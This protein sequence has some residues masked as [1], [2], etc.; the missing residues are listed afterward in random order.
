[1]LLHLDTAEALLQ[2]YIETSAQ[3]Q[4]AAMRRLYRQRASGSAIGCS[5]DED[6]ALPQQN[7]SLLQAVR[8]VYTGVGVQLKV[9]AV[10]QGHL[11]LLSGAGGEIRA[12]GGGA[13][14][15]K[16]RGTGGQHHQH[17]Q[18]LAPLH[19]HLRQ[20]WQGHIWRYTAQLLL[21][22]FDARPGICVPG[23][24]AK[25]ALPSHALV[26]TDIDVVECQ[27]PLY[28]RLQV[29]LGRRIDMR[30]AQSS[31]SRMH[32]IS[33]FARWFFTVVTD[34]PNCLPTCT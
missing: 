32:C 9:T 14:T 13:V 11:P 33:A 4:D 23:V 3:G 21:E 7:Q 12:V 10:R 2:A 1:M 27:V 30:T 28:C 26:A 5:G 17:L 6:F 16:S 25:P 24:S 22:L 34:S 15:C 8:D 31:I 20:H 19:A 29:L 18:A